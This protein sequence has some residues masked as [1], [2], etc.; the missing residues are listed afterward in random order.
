MEVS[1]NT[2]RRKRE[3]WEQRGTKNSLLGILDASQDMNAHSIA[4]DCCVLSFDRS[5]AFLLFSFLSTAH[6]LR[7]RNA[8][9][10]VT[11][12]GTT[13]LSLVVNAIFHD[14]GCIS[15]LQ[16]VHPRGVLTEGVT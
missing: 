5:A 15:K 13:E 14:R 3:N 1:R 10:I 8:G 9:C 2:L 16:V 6:L 4:L 12:L 7:E 11:Y